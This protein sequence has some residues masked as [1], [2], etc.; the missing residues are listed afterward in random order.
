MS[1]VAEV[2]ADSPLVYW[3]LDEAS[4]AFADATGHT[5]DAVAYGDP[6]DYQQPPGV[7]ERYSI[8]NDTN[9]RAATSTEVDFTDPNEWTLEA[10]I[11]TSGPTG[12]DGGMGII[13]MGAT[14]PVLRVEAFGGSGRLQLVKSFTANDGFSTVSVTDDQWH[15]VV[16]RRTGGV[17]TI[18]V[19]GVDRS[20]TMANPTYQNNDSPTGFGAQ[21]SGTTSTPNSPYPNSP[22]L[23]NLD[24]LAIYDSALP[25]ARIQA[26][27]AAGALAFA[28]WL[29][30]L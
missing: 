24:E 6:Y 2:L 18:W 29:T 19:D 11:K 17:S 10:W 15:H 13:E 12:G 22:F 16:A 7:G 14:S 3:K 4:G 20:G 5:A 8:F 27:F 1:Y 21:W 25:D 23:G 9:S 26:H 30:T 28:P